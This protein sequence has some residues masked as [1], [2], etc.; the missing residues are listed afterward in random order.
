MPN[1]RSCVFVVALDCLANLIVVERHFRCVG[2][3]PGARGAI[4]LRRF[5]GRSRLVREFG[6]CRRDGH[7]RFRYLTIENVV[8][9]IG[10]VEPVE[11]AGDVER[12][13]ALIARSGGHGRRLF[14]SDPPSCA[15]R[16]WRATLA[17]VVEQSRGR[18]RCLRAIV[19]P[20][21]AHRIPHTSTV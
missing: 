8:S 3:G 6:R 18:L 5:R 21:S 16:A 10:T 17:S 14:A 15:H 11:R 7:W 1:R 2:G 13:L 20:Y 4:D 9:A 12:R 19:V